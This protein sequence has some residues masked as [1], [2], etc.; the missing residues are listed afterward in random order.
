MPQFSDDQSARIAGLA[1]YGIGAT[2]GSDA[3]DQEGAAR[4]LLER[5][6]G[7]AVPG[8]LRPQLEGGHQPGSGEERGAAVELLARKVKWLAL[9]GLLPS[10]GFPRLAIFT[11][12][13]Q[14]LIQPGHP[15]RDGTA[16]EDAI[17]MPLAD[18]EQVL[19]RWRARNTPRAG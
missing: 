17:R 10:V 12:T 14:E 11:S 2:P 6:A 16:F 7:G 19:V 8:W 9:Y 4:W 13:L 3:V 1:R 5:L 18:L 15:M